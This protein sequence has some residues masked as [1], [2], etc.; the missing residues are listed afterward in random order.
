[1]AKTNRCVLSGGGVA[2][3]VPADGLV[4]ETAD[5]DAVD[6]PPQPVDAPDATSVTAIAVS[7]TERE[8]VTGLE[9]YGG[10]RLAVAS[11]TLPITH[12]RVESPANCLIFRARCP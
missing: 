1:M 11:R 2:T 8:G 5:G 10:D 6:L 9:V 12:L 3:A 7:D 4:E